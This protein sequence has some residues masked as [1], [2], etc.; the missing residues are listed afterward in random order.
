VLRF[1]LVDAV[2]LVTLRHVVYVGNVHLLL[3]FDHEVCEFF[4]RQN[5]N[6]ILTGMFDLSALNILDVVPQRQLLVSDRVRIIFYVVA[7][8]QLR[9]GLCWR[10]G[11][12]TDIL[13]LA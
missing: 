5:L 7:L 3:H 4:V 13:D 10:L 9:R 2:A 6:W 12:S 8:I 1:Q 11:Q